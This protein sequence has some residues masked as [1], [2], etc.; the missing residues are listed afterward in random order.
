MPRS[1]DRFRHTFATSWRG[2]ILVA[3]LVAVGGLIALGVFYLS[4]QQARHAEQQ[5]AQ[6]GM[7]VLWQTEHQVTVPLQAYYLA[8]LQQLAADPELAK[9]LQ[10]GDGRSLQAE[11]LSLRDRFPGAL[12]IR[13]VAAGYETSA[14]DAESLGYATL[15]MLRQAGISRVRPPVEAHF[16]GAQQ[17]QQVTIVQPVLSAA[18]KVAGNLVLLL[19]WDI[20][21]Q[22]WNHGDV[23]G[24][25]LELLQGGNTVLARR[26]D[27]AL[28]LAPAP[29]ALP[30]ENT[31][32][33]LAYWPPPPGP[34]YT[35]WIGLPVTGLLLVVALLALWRWKRQ[36]EEALEPVLGSAFLR[37]PEQLASLADTKEMAAPIPAAAPR[38]AN[39]MLQSKSVAP[40]AAGAAAASEEAVMTELDDY[41]RSVHEQAPEPEL[42]E[43]VPRIEPEEIEQPIPV[44][45]LE[46]E[47]EMGSGYIQMESADQAWLFDAHPEMISAGMHAETSIAEPAP[48][49]AVQEA[50]TA[51]DEAHTHAAASEPAAME[52]VFEID[53]SGRLDDFFM[54]EPGAPQPAAAAG[55]GDA[56]DWR[57]FQS[58][59]TSLP[60]SLFRAFDIRGIVGQTLMPDMFYQLG[61]A[62]GS[63]ALDRGINRLVVGRDGR[64][65]SG[66]LTE[67]LTSG[68]VAA[69]IQVSDLGMVPTPILYFAIN[70]LGT[71]S[72]VMVTGSHDP[73][74]HNG[75]KIVLDGDTLGADGIQALHGRILKGD[76]RS[77][78]GGRQMLDTV[79]DYIERITA[80][81]SL[82][83]PFRVVVDG[84]NGVAGAVAPRLLR[85]LGCE[86][87][88]LYCDVDGRFPNHPPDP[89]RAEHLEDLVL[90]VKEQG[91]DLGLAFDG[92]GDRLG[93]VDDAGNIIAPDRQLMLYAADVLARNPG[94]TIVYDVRCSAN[95]ERTVT[96][97]RGHPVM[98]KSGAALIRA[99]MKETAALLG[100]N[101]DGCIFFKERWYGFADALYA[102]VRLMRI[103]ARIPGS[104]SAAFADFPAAMAAPEYLIELPDGEHLRLMQRLQELAPALEKERFPGAR[105]TTLDGLRVDFNDRW[106]LV[107]A[108]ESSASLIARFEGLTSEALGRIQEEL[109]ALLLE[110]EPY[111]ILPF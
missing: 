83:R 46:P 30:L 12:G 103:L 15:D 45:R 44:P 19:P 34:L 60:A 104:P 36:S 89:S 97:Y 105:I 84:A 62:V 18:G 79:P 108:C 81:V 86:V 59:S 17:R 20:I 95:L 52:P 63:E 107:M 93:V 58:A 94:A 98:W 77:G 66:I 43:E 48:E 85:A 50:D 61:R 8:R 54:A 76:L 25:Y 35:L 71:R 7:E 51:M 91:A 99:R 101:M 111:L 14:L 2:P 57:P 10:F 3:V 82:A 29:Y 26:G 100:G 42:A 109:R 22:P 4:Q 55:G 68:L 47:P 78:K 9:L 40:Q 90:T 27:P 37:P 49:L 11:E 87:I 64:L 33:Q 80:A 13:L 106:G 38:P 39:I 41:W 67:A 69:G 110:V 31:R 74:N 16:L 56:A 32:W 24:G 73:P 70:H 5:R 102:A 88:E 65:T 96:R 28:K 1:T 92:D 53:P 23:K 75:L 72:G 6:Q 21:R